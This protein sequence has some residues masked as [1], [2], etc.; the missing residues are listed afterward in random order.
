MHAKCIVVDERWSL[1]GSANFTRRTQDRNYEF[2]LLVE[3]PHLGHGLCVQW[4]SLITS[5]QLSR[6]T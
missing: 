1:V 5:G 4:R 2:G 6:H 3:D